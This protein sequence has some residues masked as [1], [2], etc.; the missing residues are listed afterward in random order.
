MLTLTV[1]V[2]GNVVGTGTGTAKPVAKRNA[3]IQALQ[4]FRAHGV[5]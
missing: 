2:R 5:S 1:P 4:Y 3:A